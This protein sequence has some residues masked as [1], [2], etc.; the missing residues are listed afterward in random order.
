MKLPLA[1]EASSSLNT[2]GGVKFSTNLVAALTNL[3]SEPNWTR[4]N[5]VISE[6]FSMRGRFVSMYENRRLVESPFLTSSTIKSI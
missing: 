3:V 1:T 4:F 6:V 2:D 5:E